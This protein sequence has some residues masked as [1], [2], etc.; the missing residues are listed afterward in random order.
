MADVTQAVECLMGSPSVDR[1]RDY[2][3]ALKRLPQTNPPT[4]HFFA[5]GLYGRPMY[6]QAGESVVGAT[7]AKQHLCVVMGHCLVVDGH[8]RKELK[9]WNVFVSEPGAK[10][11]IIALE[12]T[13]WMTVHAT[14]KTDVE[15]VEREVLQPEP[16]PSRFFPE[17]DKALEDAP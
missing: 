4:E 7:H 13:V 17:G 6:M 5:D 1:I 9:G 16:E 14:D 8:D 10:R 3:A 12:D 11:A 15:A 2:E